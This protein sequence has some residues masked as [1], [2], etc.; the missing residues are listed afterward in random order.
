MVIMN[1]LI[2]MMLGPKQGYIFIST[3]TTTKKIF[4]NVQQKY[5]VVMM[6]MRHD[7]DT[8]FSSLTQRLLNNNTMTIRVVTSAA[9]H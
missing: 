8:V 4:I 1:Q 2:Q 3:N 5:L 6:H 7:H 9:S